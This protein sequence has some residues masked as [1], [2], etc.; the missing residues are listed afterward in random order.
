[1]NEEDIL[2]RVTAAYLKTEVAEWP[3]HRLSTVEEIDGKR[4]A[5]LRNAYR[6]LAVYHVHEDGNFEDLED[7][8]KSIR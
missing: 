5:V 3:N 4:Y 7:W 2:T 8:P 1:M 6:V